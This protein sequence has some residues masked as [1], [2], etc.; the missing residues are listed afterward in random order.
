MNVFSKFSY[1]VR[2]SLS[3]GFTR[4]ARKVKGY[5][6][7]ILALIFTAGILADTFK[8]H[9]TGNMRQAGVDMMVKYRFLV[10]KPDKDIVIVDIDEASLAEMAAEY[11][12]WPWPRQVMGEFVKQIEKQHPQAI[13]FD[14]IFSDPDVYN[15]DSDKYFNDEI[16]TTDNTYFPMLRLDPFDDQHSQLNPALIPGAEPA[17]EGEVFGDATIAMLMP[18][19]QSVQ[20]SGRM[21]LSNIDPDADG[22]TRQY[23][24]YRVEYGWKFPSLPLRVAEGLKFPPMNQ[25]HVFLNWRGPAFTYHSV[26]FSK[27]FTDFT[28]K[29]KSRPQ[30]E[31]T[32]KIV[33]IGSTASGLFDVKPTPLSKAHPGVEILATAID[34]F[35]H[36]DYLRIPDSRGAYLII[37][38][39]VIWLTAWAFY[40]DTFREKLDPIF[41]ASQVI[42]IA[43]SYGSINLTNTYINLTGPVTLSLA[44]FTVA[45]L[46]ALAAR[47]VLE[48]SAV[49][50]S[51]QQGNTHHG[52]LMLVNLSAPPGA[53]NAGVREKIRGAL[54]KVGSAGKSVEILKG[55]QKDLW[56]LFENTFAISWITAESDEA[57]RQRI[58]EDIAQI[59]QAILP[60]LRKYYMASGSDVAITVQQGE[61]HSGAQGSGQWQALFGQALANRSD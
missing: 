47:S 39:L 36:G 52:V 24:A 42:L 38:L 8:F 61:I 56:N 21:G 1:L 15:P 58:E 35:K 32:N 2:S 59:R 37:T 45:R 51:L 60:I 29:K 26:S 18:Y 27:V 14:I 17:G 16:A 30:D 3:K 55:V 9:F 33:I 12:R 11:G 49:R 23:Q 7:L 20:E 41:G 28:N 48:R 19:F 34:N 5:M 46:Y 44:F 10:P 40:R 53:L 25:Q 57:G 50:V 22:V 31:F 4:F 43:V 13:V 54:L 6:Y